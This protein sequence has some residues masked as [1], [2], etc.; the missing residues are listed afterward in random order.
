MVKGAWATLLTRASYLP[1]VILLHHS[2]KKVGSAY[3]LIVLYTPSL[4]S[5]AVDAL[6]ALG[7]ELISTE[8]LRPKV[9]VSVVAERFADTWDKLRVFELTGYDRLVLIDGDMVLFRSMDDLFDMD[10][11]EGWI[12]ANHTCLCNWS[13]DAWAPDEWRPWTCAYTYAQEHNGEPPQPSEHGMSLEPPH[14][15][16]LMNSGL[17]VLQPSPVLASAIEFFVHTSPLVSTFSFPDQDFLGVFFARKW[18]ALKWDVNAIKISRYWHP[19]LWSDGGV[20]NLH[21]IVDKPWAVPREKWAA[22]DVVTHEWWWQR[23]YEW[24]DAQR[25]AGKDEIVKECERWM[26]GRKGAEALE[27]QTDVGAVESWEE[28]VQAEEQ[29]R[30]KGYA[31]PPGPAWNIEV[32]GKKW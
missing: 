14:T 28:S 31:W 25:S 13:R 3:P 9:P 22:K 1:G 23:Y 15:Y 4:E 2:L 17:V 27:G 12:A 29:G 20:R 21:Y 30:S 19:E 6:K 16:A 26:L 10:L 8:P 24:R 5:T 32:D 18:K 7:I 11:P